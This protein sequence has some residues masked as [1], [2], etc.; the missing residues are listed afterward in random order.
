MKENPPYKLFKNIIIKGD[1][2]FPPD[3]YTL[4]DIKKCA[5]LNNYL[6]FRGTFWIPNFKPLWMAILYK[7]YNSLITGHPV[8]HV[9]GYPAK[10]RDRSCDRHTATATLGRVTCR[11][12]WWVM[13]QVMCWHLDLGNLPRALG[14]KALSAALGLLAP[15]ATPSLWPAATLS[16][17]PTSFVNHGR[18]RPLSLAGPWPSALA[19]LRPTAASGPWGTL[20]H[21]SVPGRV[22][23]KQM[24]PKD[25]R[26]ID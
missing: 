4:A 11:V 23:C 19:G 17:W 1:Y 5:V 6:Y 12:M 21:D 2:Q 8:S 9:T 20:G 22:A 25:E 15:M 14:L 10:S 16:S 18:W 3:L 7:I 13:C 26:T 24:V